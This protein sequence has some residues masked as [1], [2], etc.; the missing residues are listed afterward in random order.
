LTLCHT[1]HEAAH[2][3]GFKFRW[4]KH[5]EKPTSASVPSGI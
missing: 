5:A 1:C 4:T 3:R 2:G